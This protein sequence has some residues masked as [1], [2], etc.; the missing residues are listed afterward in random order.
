M[1]TLQI[2][3]KCYTF[4]PSKNKIQEKNDDGSA[5]LEMRLTK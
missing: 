5:N 2:I 1:G 3:S 4:L